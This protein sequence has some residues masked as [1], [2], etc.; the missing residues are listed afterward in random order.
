LHFNSTADRVDDA[1]E[2]REHSIAGILYDAPAMLPDLRIDEIA[3][4]PS[5]PLMCA[6]LIRSH[7]PRIAGHIGGEDRGCRNT[8]AAKPK[9]ASR[10]RVHKRETWS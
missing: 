8:P 6:L 3:E 7:Q 1:G 10:G 2:F 4:M 9:S 5:Q